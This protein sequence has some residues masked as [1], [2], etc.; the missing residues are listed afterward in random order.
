MSLHNPSLLNRRTRT[1]F[2]STE[3]VV[4]SSLLVAVMAVIGPLTVRNVRLLRDARHQ[5]LALEELS[6]EME[7][8]T[9]LQGDAR[10]QAIEDLAPSQWLAAAAPDVEI[11]GEMVDDTDGNRLILSLDWNQPN[12]P[13]APVRLV[14]W[15]NPLPG[16]ATP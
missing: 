3:L 14:G 8:L 15:L 5:Q 11:K 9:A 10:V 2:T 13:R 16:E 6:S 4:A 1:G 12:Y 7:R